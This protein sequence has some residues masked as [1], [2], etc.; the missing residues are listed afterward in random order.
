MPAQDLPFT[1]AAILARLIARREISPVELT[2]L[3][4]DHI[5]ALN[6]T[7]N[8]YITVDEHGALAAARDAESA[9]LRGDA[10]GPL[11]GVPVSVKDLFWTKGLRTTAG[12]ALYRD[13]VP[14]ED[15]IPVRRL[16]E[17]GM[18]VLGKASTPEFGL[19]ATTENALIGP[20]RNPWN[21]ART[22]GGSSGGSAAAVAAGLGPLSLA[23]DGGG[24]IRIPSS[25]C[26]VFG[27]KPTRGRVP[28]S[29]GFGNRAWN[30]WTQPGPI[31]RTVEDAALMLQAIA[32][33]DRRDVLALRQ[34]PPDFLAPLRQGVRGLRIGLSLDLGYAAVDPEVATAVRAAAGG[35][36]G[37]GAH[38]E[39]ADINLGQ[40]F[41]P[42]WTVFA[43]NAWAAYGDLMEQ[44]RERLGELTIT[45][46]ET[47]MLVT[48]AE[49]S[50]ALWAFD[51]LAAKV[52]DA[53]ERY[54]LLLTPTTPV[55][56]FPLGRRPTVIGGKQVHPLWSFNPYAF[57]FNIT[58]NPAASIPCGFSREGLP[59]GLHIVGPLGDEPTVLRAA[60]AYEATRPWAHQRPPLTG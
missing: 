50:Q 57:V 44:H 51:R 31:A 16:R 43:A 11:H 26:G 2:R 59:F 19:S 40:P 53:F 1:S 5:A 22:S 45:S 58:G 21:T 54:D 15:S 10:L 14:Q 23:N 33:P 27:I 37:L 3:L 49:Y 38:V 55:P 28:R 48:G 13:H 46:L 18:V 60:A 17:A 6:P 29:G 34:P 35:L 8:A 20:T 30:T 52:A 24:S 25:F 56:A 32:G 41:D 39:E 42:F 7:L 47:G 4:L 12:S 9:I 36:E